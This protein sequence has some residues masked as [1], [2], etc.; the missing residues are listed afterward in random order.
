MYSLSLKNQR[1]RRSIFLIIILTVLVL[2][3][4][5]RS[6]QLVLFIITYHTGIL[7]S[8]VGVLIVALGL[9]KKQNDIL[10]ENDRLYRELQK[11]QA[12]INRDL[13]MARALQQ[14]ILKEKLP[15]TKKFEI[16]AE[17]RPA[18]KI[19]GDFYSI[20]L[21]ENEL[22]FFVGDVSGHG[23]SSALIMSLTHGLINEIAANETSPA[24]ILH[25]T[26]YLLCNYLENNINYVTLFYGKIDLATN[27]LTYCNAGHPPAL[28]YQKNKNKFL[29]LA[30]TSSILGTF[31]DSKFKSH[32][33]LLNKNDKLIIYTDGFIEL[34][35]HGHQLIKENLFYKTI[36]K[37]IELS[38]EKLKQLVYG[39]ISQQ[40]DTHN[41]DL[42]LVAIKINQ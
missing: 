30:N 33:L 36:E 12:L 22:H 34:K 13:E 32:T 14:G 17:C 25:K 42:S 40:A 6:Q 27:K 15:V 16:A 37:N 9:Q 3:V 35:D 1:V 2:A 19:G 28:L 20:K 23:I 11:K 24:K 4:A 39:E 8:A 26:N 29:K 41:D 18:E 7:F 10:K 21:L 31:N 38:P 5:T